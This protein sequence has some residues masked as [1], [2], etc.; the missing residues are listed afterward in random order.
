MK[1]K[2]AFSFASLLW[3]ISALVLSSCSTGNNSQSSFSSFS[4][5]ETTI[6]SNPSKDTS[7]DVDYSSNRWTD[8]SGHSLWSVDDES[9]MF[10]FYS[11]VSD[12]DDVNRWDKAFTQNML[13]TDQFDTRGTIVTMEAT[14]KG[15][16]STQDLIDGETD[17]VHLGIVPWYKD[18]DNWVLCYAKFN[19]ETTTDN[20]GNV[21]GT[22]KDG[23]LTHFIVYVKLNGST[24]VEF[25]VKD[26]SYYDNKWI[27]P[28]DKL[29]T[30]WHIAWPDRDNG[31]KSPTSLQETEPDPSEE[32]TILVRKTRKTYAQKDCDSF[33]VKV[34]DYEL[35]FGLDNFMFSGLKEAEAADESFIP[36]V[37]FYLYG[38]RRAIVRDFSIDVSD[39][40]ILP[41]P[42]VEPLSSPTTNGTINKKIKV[43]DFAAYNNDG[44]SI[45]YS[46]TITGPDGETLY[47]DGEDYF[48]PTKAGSYQIKASAK[49]GKY[50]GE[51]SYAVKVKDGTAHID[52]DV[53]DDVL[54]PLAKDTAI[55][56]AYVIFISVPILIA[57]YIGFKVFMCFRKKKKGE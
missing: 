41:I 1:R 6:S 51:Y 57:G 34:N 40:E 26:D 8:Y 54:T 18:S 53:Y 38:T 10:N 2:I 25:Y 19:R 56:A 7:L 36:K 49:D 13:I 45:D 5:S 55:I 24:N 43:P 22:I 37:G 44:E 29:N 48:I 20:D 35:N 32:T 31:S 46:L 15:T 33:Y 47:L 9:S 4:S 11:S 12:A 16:T 17:E 23:R 50:V 28:E 42:T 30:E 27:S 39:E 3:L 14:F 52:T 21:I